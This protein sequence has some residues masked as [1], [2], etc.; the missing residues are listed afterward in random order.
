MGKKKQLTKKEENSLEIPEYI[1]AT[2]ALDNTPF[3]VP[4]YQ[5]DRTSITRSMKIGDKV[6]P[7]G[8]KADI[9]SHVNLV[10]KWGL[11][12]TQDLDYF[13]AFEK[14]CDEIVNRDGTFDLPI[15]I[16]TKKLLRYAGKEDCKREWREVKI[17]LKRM[18]A[19]Q[20]E[21]IWSAKSG[22]FE[23]GAV[24][25]FAMIYTKG[26]KKKDGTTA[27]ANYIWPNYW[28]LEN[29]IHRHVRLIDHNFY[30][31]LTK[32][33]SKALYGLLSTGWYASGGNPYKKS[34]N[35]LSTEFFIKTHTKF[36]YIKQQLDPAHKEL[37]KHGFLKKWEY[38][39]SKNKK[40][41]VIIWYAGDK[42]HKDQTARLQRKQTAKQIAS[43]SRVY[44][45]FEPLNDR[46]EY[47]VEKIMQVCKDKDNIVSYEKIVREKSES[48][49]ESSLGET[50]H[51]IR[52]GQIKKTPGAY[53]TDMIK[54][55]ENDRA[56]AK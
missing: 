53:F 33:I 27:E 10:Q 32:P 14:Y 6:L 12:N 36:S 2:L 15:K 55:L 51:A 41:Y 7:D 9:M 43:G 8:T 54:R 45:G 11:P 56:N 37:T 30:K 19:T 17:W 35:T 1:K 4:T 49:I 23:D 50:K 3:F 34:Y 38:V 13:R 29:Y 20:I 52:T 40:D 47:L 21:G 18:Q 22:E 31:S 24:S 26:Q 42:Y 44:K 28:F 5:R 48:L 39:Q 46:Q 16:T 25:V